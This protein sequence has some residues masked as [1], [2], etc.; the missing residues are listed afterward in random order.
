MI[1]DDQIEVAAKA[2]REVVANRSGKGCKWEALPRKVKES[3][4][5]EAQAALSAA[6]VSGARLPR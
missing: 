4:R 1:T 6:N 3:Y 2:I 5:A